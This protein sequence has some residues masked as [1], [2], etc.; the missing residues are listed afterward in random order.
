MYRTA[1][2]MPVPA[3]RLRCRNTV[4]RKKTDKRVTSLQDL[5][6]LAGVSRATA[7]RAL[8]DSPML[9]DKTK[10][11]LKA[12]AAEH[13]YSI[14]RQAR[15]LR[16]S[17]TSVIAVV[18]MLDSESGQ[19]MSDPFFMAILGEIADC[20]AEH[21]Y[22]L[23]L[24]RAPIVDIRDIE[25]SRPIRQSDGV[26]F[27]GQSEQ[28]RQIDELAQRGIPIVV[29][30]FP[31]ADKHYPVVGSDNFS[32]GYQA[33]RH[34]V[35]TGRRRIAFFGHTRHPENA[36]R[37]DGYVAALRE[38]GIKVSPRLKFDVPFEMERAREII[39]GIIE[40]G[41]QFDAVV[42]ASDVIALASISTFEEAGIAVPG[43]IA[44][45]GY[46]NIS[47]SE[48]SSPA[49]TTVSQSLHLAG[50]ALVESLLR[51]INGET[52]EDTMLPSELIVRRSSV[53]DKKDGAGMSG[54]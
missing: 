43:D 36:A 28:R 15:D 47:L 53:R 4:M 25:S 12:L 39:L 34:L 18:F 21:D 23:L 24:A 54:Q 30:G 50:R 2:E 26:I 20:L 41:L 1:I 29:W 13:N 37:F 3:A 16:L 10:A 51:V 52:V 40:S 45:V 9:N 19:H 33:T 14:N 7:S 48:Y 49:L 11:R 17:R 31:V 46:D 35:E 42:C 6:D 44:V 22:D 32:G 5:A 38:S 8:N 27:I